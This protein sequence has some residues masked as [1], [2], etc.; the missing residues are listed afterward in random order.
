MGPSGPGEAKEVLA[1]KTSRRESDA[2]LDAS[3][4]PNFKR[5]V[6]TCH[7][8]N[9]SA[10]AANTAGDVCPTNGAAANDPEVS[11]RATKRAPIS[12]EEDQAAPHKT[13]LSQHEV[14]D[15]QE[16]DTHRQRR[17]RSKLACASLRKRPILPLINGCRSTAPVLGLAW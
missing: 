9:R 14:N 5:R 4:W 3:G 13:A 16:D 6:V 15:T 2:A 17:S 12:R 1:P 10:S 11:R 8:R 7:R